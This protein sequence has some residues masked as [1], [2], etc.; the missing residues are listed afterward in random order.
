MF[1]E[2]VQELK[3]YII[4]FVIVLVIAFLIFGI[5]HIL[6]NTNE[7][8]RKK[9]IKA[10]EFSGFTL[11]KDSDNLLYGKDF[12]GKTYKSYKIST[13]KGEDA[14]YKH[15]SFNPRSYE[16][17][18]DYFEY[19]DGAEAELSATYDYK[20]DKI[21]YTYNVRLDDS[22]LIFSGKLED[23]YFTCNLKYNLNAG[24]S[25][26]DDFCKE[27]KNLVK[28]FDSERLEVITSTE[29]LNY[30]KEK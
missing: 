24:T 5:M 9:V 21:K 18:E 28:N 1:V 17:T 16:L 15:L 26:R 4:F 29:I 7:N 23:E 20:S 12:D 8:K 25:V 14:T 2:F 10:I 6:S 11:D 30:M 22:N 13:S 19:D 27:I 3:K